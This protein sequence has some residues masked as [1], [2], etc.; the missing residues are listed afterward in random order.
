MGGEWKFSFKYQN[1]D[2]L[3]I[4]K[5][6]QSL[7]KLR[8]EFESE[9]SMMN[10][11]EGSVE[12]ANLTANNSPVNN[13]FAKFSYHCT[14]N[15]FVNGPGHGT[16]TLYWNPTEKTAKNDIHARCAPMFFKDVSNQIQ[17]KL[18]EQFPDH[19]TVFWKNGLTGYEGYGASDTNQQNQTDGNDMV[20]QM[21]VAM[22][23]NDSD[24]DGGDRCIH[25]IPWGYC[26]DCSDDIMD[27]HGSF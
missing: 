16:W 4:A 27:M 9:F 1:A 21:M 19:F 5:Y 26:C 22:K 10:A 7:R 25:H 23:W 8:Q 13:V 20:R 14:K 24:S 15:H 11:I 6:Q 17:M 2:S 18:A 12:W 3:D